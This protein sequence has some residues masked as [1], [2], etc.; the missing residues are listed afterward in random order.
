MANKHFGLIRVVSFEDEEIAQK[1]GRLIEAAFP[2]LEVT[3]RCIEDQPKGIYD[4]ATEALAVPKIVRLGVRFARE[5][6]IGGLIISCA[7]DPAVEE[8][9]SELRIPVIGAG[10]AAAALALTYGDRVGT[11]GITEETPAA[12]KKVLGS[13]LM[14]EAK[15]EGVV[16]TLD[17]MT[18]EGKQQALEAVER[19]KDRGAQ[20][21]ALA[22]TG[23]ATI[24]LAGELETRAGIPVIDAVMAAGLAAWFLAR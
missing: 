10:R 1:H 8:L 6:R 24:G 11:L 4:D 15:P 14:A 17:L 21:V 7:A 23:Y 22:C 5:G 18:T 19:L 20:V 12:M 9:R 3:S 13:H 16:N 2:D